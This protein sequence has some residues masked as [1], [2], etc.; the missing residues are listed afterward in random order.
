MKQLFRDIEA[1]SGNPLQRQNTLMSLGLPSHTEHNLT[2]IVNL[3]YPGIS[4]I[5]NPRNDTVHNDS[6]FLLDGEE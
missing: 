5:G 3:F 4:D 6:I 2:Y 1:R